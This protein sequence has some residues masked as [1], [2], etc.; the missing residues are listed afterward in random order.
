MRFSLFYIFSFLALT[1]CN[2][3]Y[4]PTMANVPLHDK[5]G[6]VQLSANY[7]YSGGELQ[8]SGAL[9]NHL[10]LSANGQ[11]LRKKTKEDSLSLYRSFEIAVGYYSWLDKAKTVKLDLAAGYGPGDIDYRF[12]IE[13][14]PMQL[15][16]HVASKYHKVF[17]QP[18]LGLNTEDTDFAISLKGSVM[19]HY[20]FTDYYNPSQQHKAFSPIGYLEPILTVKKG[21]KNI[22]LL[23]QAG[24]VWPLTPRHYLSRPIV[25][26]YT[27]IGLQVKFGLG[28][29]AVIN[30]EL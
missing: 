17:I 22:R 27:G 15:R 30:G 28:K 10:Y 20:D 26:P 19:Y 21:I 29:K 14:I 12:L 7:G 18:S 5:A 8:L 25:F 24:L 4:K 2:T 3:F 11:F 9:T 6:D 23:V 13:T 1:G 16:F